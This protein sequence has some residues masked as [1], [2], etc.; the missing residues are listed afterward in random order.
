MLGN[1]VPEILRSFHFEAGRRPVSDHQCQLHNN[2]WN[3]NLAA[4]N[5]ESS[6][7]YSARPGDSFGAHIACIA[8]AAL[9]VSATAVT[10]CGDFTHQKVARLGK[11]SSIQ[12]RYPRT[13]NSVGPSA[14]CSLQLYWYDIPKGDKSLACDDHDEHGN[15][16][17]L[18]RQ[19]ESCGSVKNFWNILL[20][21]QSPNHQFDC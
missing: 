12:P 3:L 13:S 1:R 4:C 9:R 18:Q 7:P 15:R 2:A 6:T 19:T 21:T 10:C 16:E 5:M 11:S 14:S 20:I 8:P 17:A